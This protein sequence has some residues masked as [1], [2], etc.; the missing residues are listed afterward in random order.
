VFQKV[1]RTFMLGLRCSE[2]EMR[3]KFFSLYDDAIGKT[4]FARLCYIISEQ[5][6]E[7]LADV[8]WLKQGLDILLAILVEKGP[9]EVAPNSARVRC[10]GICAS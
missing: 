9:I 6:W 8:F 5:D 1:E 2:P 4:L 7:A 10:H 3:Q